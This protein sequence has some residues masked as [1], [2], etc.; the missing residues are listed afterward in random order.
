MKIGLYARYLQPA[1]QQD[2]DRLVKALHRHHV[3]TEDITDSLSPDGYDFIISVGGDGT[4]LSSVHLI[5]R[6]QIPVVGVNLGHLGFLTTAGRDDIDTLVTDLLA[7][8]YTVEPRTLLHVVADLPG[9]PS[10]TSA[11]LRTSASTAP[12][13]S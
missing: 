13:T 11:N 6:R 8:R 3:V 1:A 9:S 7:G 4:L 12:K 10:S 2:L 5:G